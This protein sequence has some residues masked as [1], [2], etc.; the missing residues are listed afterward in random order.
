[1]ATTI[2][3]PN[4]NTETIHTFANYRVIGEVKVRRYALGNW[5]GNAGALHIRDKVSNVFF[6]MPSK[7][8]YQELNSNP[9]LVKNTT[10]V[11]GSDVIRILVIGEHDKAINAISA[12]ITSISSYSLQEDPETG[13]LLFDLIFEFR[14]LESS[15][16]MLSTIKTVEPHIAHTFTGVNGY[17]MIVFEGDMDE[18]AS[19]IAPQY[20]IVRMG[21]ELYYQQRVM[22]LY[23]TIGPYVGGVAVNPPV[24]FGTAILLSTSKL[25]ISETEYKNFLDCA[26]IYLHSVYDFVSPDIFSK[27]SEVVDE[28]NV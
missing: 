15:N 25:P 4:V 27:T 6:N 14:V 7:I 8:L 13:E 23:A 1:M 5:D 11:S 19:K 26:G 28:D 10:I 21:N 17:A 12:L 16:L 3:N 18:I 9:D 20:S 22:G 24:Y 2:N